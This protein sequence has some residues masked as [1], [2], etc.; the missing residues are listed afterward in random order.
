MAY[1]PA[2]EQVLEDVNKLTEVGELTAY[3]LDRQA[4]MNEIRE[5]RRR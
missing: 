1:G 3:L 5:V 4:R 2:L